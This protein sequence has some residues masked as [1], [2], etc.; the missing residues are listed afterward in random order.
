MTEA[1]NRLIQAAKEAGDIARGELEPVI[2]YLQENPMTEKMYGTLYIRLGDEAVTSAELDPPIPGTRIVAMSQ[3]SSG[4]TL[5]LVYENMGTYSKDHRFPAEP[6]W[7]EA[8]AK[9]I[10]FP[11]SITLRFNIARENLVWVPESGLMPSEREETNLADPAN[12]IY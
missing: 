4:I 12:N 1:G 3:N 8:L 10:G 6:D 2:K 11:A 7:V 5:E 9:H